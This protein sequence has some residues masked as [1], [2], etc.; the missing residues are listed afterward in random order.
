MMLTGFILPKLV[1]ISWFFCTRWWTF[2][3]CKKWSG[4][5]LRT[6]GL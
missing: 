4:R 5:L 3:L 6:F 2:G 1:T